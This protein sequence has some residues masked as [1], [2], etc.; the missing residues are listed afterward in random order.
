[1]G[2]KHPHGNSKKCT[3]PTSCLLQTIHCTGLSS[4]AEAGSGIIF[5][6]VEGKIKYDSGG[7]EG[8]GI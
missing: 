2:C 5:N 6:D 7:A 1:M 8:N 3:V 4:G